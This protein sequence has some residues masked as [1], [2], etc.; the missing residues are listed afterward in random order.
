MQRAALRLGLT[1]VL[2]LLLAEQAPGALIMYTQSGTGSGHLGSS[3][4]TNALV[5]LVATADTS[6]I[7]NAASLFTVPAAS[8]TVNVLEVPEPPRTPPCEA[9]PAFT[10]IMLVPAPLI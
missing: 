1:A 2:G 9:L 10:V 3:V 8:S 6:N 5:T 7:S 4:F